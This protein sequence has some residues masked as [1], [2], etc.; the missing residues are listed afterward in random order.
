MCGAFG[1]VEK[2]PL[3]VF[4]VVAKSSEC[5]HEAFGREVA[6]G[7]F[8][9]VLAD[10]GVRSLFLACLLNNARPPSSLFAAT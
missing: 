2:L 10:V 4:E 5:G 8:K 9:R 6:S 1:P 7:R 3:V